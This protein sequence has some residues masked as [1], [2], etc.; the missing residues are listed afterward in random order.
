MAQPVFFV[1]PEWREQDSKHYAY[2]HHLI[3][4]SSV[5]TEAG[6]VEWGEKEL[7]GCPFVVVQGAIDQQPMTVRLKELAK[8]QKGMTDADFYLR[9]SG[10][11]ETLGEVQKAPEKPAD[12][13]GIKV[14]ASELV[15]VDWLRIALQA[16]HGS[17]HWRKYGGGTTVQHLDEPVAGTA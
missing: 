4:V 16:V 1:A 15:S 8:I 13:W 2:G 3:L 11:L 14:T 7:D 17:G 6:A 10:D 5:T 12:W 9:R